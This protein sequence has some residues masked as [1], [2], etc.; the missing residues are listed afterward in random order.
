MKCKTC[1]NILLDSLIRSFSWI[2][3]FSFLHAFSSAAAMTVG[4]SIGDG[5]PAILSPPSYAVNTCI[6]SRTTISVRK[7]GV[8]KLEN[9]KSNV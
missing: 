5:M 1:Y 8:G 3:L 2:G 7:C 6:D 4:W 9:I